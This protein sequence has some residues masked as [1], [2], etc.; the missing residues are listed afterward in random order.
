MEFTA[1]RVNGMTAERTSEVGRKKKARWMEWQAEG[2][3]YVRIP[4]VSPGKD[5]FAYLEGLKLL[6][7]DYNWGKIPVKGGVW[8]GVK[9]RLMGAIF[10]SDLK[11]SNLRRRPG[12]T[13]RGRRLRFLGL[14]KRLK[15]ERTRNARKRVADRG[16]ARVARERRKKRKRFGD[17]EQ[18]GAMVW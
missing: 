4:F 7:E 13:E 1:R 3:E 15:W 10:D 18:E 2:G 5:F 12:C 8:R 6:K 14:T 11:I 16:L 9:R 17:H